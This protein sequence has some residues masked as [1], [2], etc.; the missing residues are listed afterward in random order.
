VDDILVALQAAHSM[1]NKLNRPFALMDDLSVQEVTGY[2]ETKAVE[3]IHPMRKDYVR[4]R[5][6]QREHFAN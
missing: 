1:A 5:D 2:T 3:I 4:S 6:G